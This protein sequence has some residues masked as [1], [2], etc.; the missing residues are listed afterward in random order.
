MIRENVLG[1]KELAILDLVGDNLQKVEQKMRL[2]GE[3]A[4]E[5]L[6]Q[7]FLQLLGS[8]GK[9][10]RPALALAAYDLLPRPVQGAKSRD[11]AGE[12]LD[13]VI[14]L[15]AAV[16]TLHN[17][18]LVH[19]DLI[20]N[21]LVRR[22]STTLNAVWDKGATV[23][24]GDYLFARAAGFA[25]ETGNIRVVELFADTLRIICEGEL[26]QHFS[27][28]QW[29][30]PR[31]SYYVRI[32]AKTASLFASAT[33]SGAILAG[34]SQAQEEALYDYGRTLGMAFQIVDDIL[35]YTGDEST[36]GKP[37]G[38]DLR[39]GIVTLPFFYYLQAHPNPAQVISMLTGSSA[40]TYA[41][42]GGNAASVDKVVAQVRASDAISQALSEARGLAGQAKASLALFPASP[43]REALQE[44]PE[45][46]VSRRL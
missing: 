45:F 26:R 29:E 6:A 16:E 39:Q 35:D 22:G 32:F 40:S 19:D 8:G 24:A 23:L 42:V 1:V 38:S 33:R 31:D 25:A 4:Y 37:V 11:L 30:Q 5:P 17:A 14:A 9:R 18:T 13:K 27:S 21:A 41:A 46:V 28:R 12:E 2:M 15:A 36:M 7:A 3:G 10:L 43:I 44:L 34:A 20:D